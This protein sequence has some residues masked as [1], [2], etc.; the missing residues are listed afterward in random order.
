[1]DSYHLYPWFCLFSWT[2]MLFSSN[3]QF[4]ELA[5]GVNFRYFFM[6]HEACIKIHIKLKRWRNMQSK[7]CTGMNNNL[8]F[9]W[10]LILQSWSGLP[11]Q[12]YAKELCTLL[13]GETAIFPC[14]QATAG[15]PT[16]WV[17]SVFLPPAALPSWTILNFEVVSHLFHVW[18]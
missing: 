11:I 15:T 1:M 5:F 14:Y 10:D 4:K 18:R 2:E 9:Q 12:P 3:L 7:S 6:C 13:R 16:V 8:H 17:C